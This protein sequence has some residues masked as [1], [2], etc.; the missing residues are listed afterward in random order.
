MI[1]FPF[2]N[3]DQTIASFDLKT[4]RSQIKHVSMTLDDLGGV[5]YIERRTPKLPPKHVQ[6]WRGYEKALLRYGLALWTDMLPG[7]QRHSP[8]RFAPYALEEA[9]S[10]FADDEDVMPPWWGNHLIHESHQRALISKKKDDIY[11]PDLPSYPQVK[12]DDEYAK[13]K[14]EHSAIDPTGFREE[15]LRAYRLEENAIM[16]YIWSSND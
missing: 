2:P 5:I 9:K 6:A 10:R 3:F 11:W 4:K 12:S 14:A 7:A 15:Q 1:Y 13:R 16:R 8:T